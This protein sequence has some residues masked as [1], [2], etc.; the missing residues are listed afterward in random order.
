MISHHRGSEKEL[1]LE[2]LKN[3]NDKLIA[4]DLD[5]TLCIGKEEEDP[6]PISAMIEKVQEWY[7][8][9]AHIIIFTA[10]PPKSYTHTAAWLTKHHVP[11]HG[12]AMSKKPA[13]DVYVDNRAL[14]I[15]DVL[16]FNE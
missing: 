4:V 8:K 10:R 1:L 2:H 9:G 5:G 14:N 12:L 16:N 13:A 6:E 7:K 3:P 15:D 11:F